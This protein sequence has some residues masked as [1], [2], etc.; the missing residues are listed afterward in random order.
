MCEESVKICR[1]NGWK[2][3][4]WLEG[5]E[6]YGPTVI[7]LRY[8]GEH[9]V[10]AKGIAHKGRLVVDSYEQLWTLTARDWETVD[11]EAVSVKLELSKLRFALSEMLRILKQR[12]PEY[13]VD[14][15]VDRIEKL[16]GMKPSTP[17]DF[18]GPSVFAVTPEDVERARAF[19]EQEV[20]NG[21]VNDVT[22]TLARVCLWA[23]DGGK[24]PQP[25]PPAGRFVRALQ[26]IADGNISPSIDF[27]RYVLEGMTVR[28]AHA[29]AK[30]DT[31]E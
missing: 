4:D 18:S 21:G 10:V 26:H 6:G 22:L 9:V 7:E 20:R 16:L 28:E 2:A 23:L 17:D 15:V 31:E 14:L 3:G 24:D 1:E 11:K 19:A 12:P 30:G 13:S 8:V 29:R 27:A 5:D 25:R